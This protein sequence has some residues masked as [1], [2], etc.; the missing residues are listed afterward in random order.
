MTGRGPWTG[1]PHRCP[2]GGCDETVDRL[3]CRAHWSLVPRA[4][5]A[6]AWAAWDSG[7]GANSIEY[8][9]AV[10]ETIDAASGPVL[11]TAC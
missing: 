4:L 8:Q 5:Q 1:E 2:A 9:R 7:R 10:R 6:Q 11:A 3:M